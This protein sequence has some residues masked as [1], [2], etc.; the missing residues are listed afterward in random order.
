MRRLLRDIAEG[1]TARRHDHARRRVR[2]RDDP[3]QHRNGGGLRHVPFGFPRRGPKKPAPAGRAPARRRLG[4]PGHPLRRP[5]RGV[6]ARRADGDRGPPLGRPQP[7][8][9]DP[10]Q[11][12]PLGAR[13][14]L[15]G[16][17]PGARPGA[18]RPVRPHRRLR[19]RRLAAV[20]HRGRARRPQAAQGALRRRPAGAAVPRHR[21]GLPLPGLGAGA[22][23]GPQHGALRA[24]HR[25]RGPAG[26]SARSTTRRSTWCSSTGPTCAASTRSTGARWRRPRALLGVRRAAATAT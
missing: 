14:R 15:G 20:A 22:A 17:D 7:A 10:D 19:R 16:D 3:R 18:D 25:R 5:H 2:G 12:G 21:D 13:R 9:V 11:R 8:R 4:E 1:R 24:R 26:R 23:A 6:A